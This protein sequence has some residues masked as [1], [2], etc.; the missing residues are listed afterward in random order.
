MARIHIKGLEFTY[1]IYDG[2]DRS[3]KLALM[4]NIVGSRISQKQNRVDVRALLGVD[5]DLKDGDRLGL[6]GRNGSGK[7]TLLKL[8]AGLVRPDAG[9]LE[10]EGRTVPL[11]SR[12]VGIN[13][14]RTGR[15]NIELPLRLLGATNAEVK[16]AQR[17]V[18]EW[19]GLGH[20]IDL[21]VRTYSQGMLARLTF[22]LSTAIDGEILILDEWMSAGDADFVAKARL[23]L[24][25]IVSRTGIVV[26]CSH[27]MRTIEQICTSV[28]WLDQGRVVMVGD[29]KSVVEAYMGSVV[30][31]PAGQE[32]QPNFMAAE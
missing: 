22:A 16:R 24:E 10:I 11:I 29:P 4:Q 25:E 8:L 7:S 9:V 27:S 15:Q 32:E 12:G 23:R 30:V 21:P 20:Y 2:A 13:P 6:I 5:L 14:E 26:L 17:E 18:P 31:A 3:L 19:T 1:P 28:C